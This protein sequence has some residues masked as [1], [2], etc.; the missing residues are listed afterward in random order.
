MSPTR[1][2][3]LLLSCLV[4]VLCLESSSPGQE[5]QQVTPTGRRQQ[6]GTGNGLTSTTIVARTFERVLMRR[7]RFLIFPVGANI[8]VSEVKRLMNRE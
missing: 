2:L 4:G 6:N 7:K 3:F 1:V 5:G 8:V